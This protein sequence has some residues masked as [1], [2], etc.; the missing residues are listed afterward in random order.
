LRDSP[1]IGEK[2]V[3]PLS[4]LLFPLQ[5]SARGIILEGAVVTTRMEGYTRL[6]G[7]SHQLEQRPDLVGVLA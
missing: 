6:L 4:S 3:V 2:P 5:W 1:R 7:R